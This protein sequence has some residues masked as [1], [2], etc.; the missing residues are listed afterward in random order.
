MEKMVEQ[1]SDTARH[2]AGAAHHQAMHG[3]ELSGVDL[4]V[5]V[6][7]VAV[8]GT[9]DRT[10]RRAGAS[11]SAA[12]ERGGRVRTAG[13]PGLHLIRS[14]AGHTR[15][16]AVSCRRLHPDLLLRARQRHLLCAL[17]VL[18]LH[19][20][21]RARAAR[22][23]PLDPLS[24]RSSLPSCLMGACLMT[25][26]AV[27]MDP[28]MASHHYWVWLQ[29]GSWFGTPLVNYAGWF[30][31]SL[32][33]MRVLWRLLRRSGWSAPLRLPPHLRV[34]SELTYAAMLL[35][36]IPPSRSPSLVVSCILFLIVLFL[37]LVSLVYLVSLVSLLNQEIKE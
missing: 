34:V 32:L 28:Y 7:C 1:C 29:Q 26:W 36:F 17:C 18:C 3:P 4:G 10:G 5:F 19:S 33:L 24:P 12:G 6:G 14:A 8:V 25:L 37:S 13:R 31:V 15:R 9:G 2:L 22:S 20:Q 35:I 16:D 21:A 11:R 27:P 23:P 30:A